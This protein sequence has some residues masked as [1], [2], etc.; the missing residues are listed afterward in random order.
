[1]AKSGTM[2]CPVDLSP[3]APPVEASGHQEWYYIRSVWHLVSLWVRLTFGQMNPLVETFNGW[4]WYSVRSSWPELR[5]TLPSRG[6]YWPRVV[7][8][9]V[10]LTIAQMYPPAEASS[11]Q[12]WY[13]V[14]SIW[15]EFIFYCLQ[16]SIECFSFQEYAFS[17]EYSV[18]SVLDVPQ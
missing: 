17:L 10:L 9:C 1:M 13:S 15:P 4:E 12:E 6:I 14:G 8:S 2:L 18:F 5:C 11:G 16:F 7:L 3:D